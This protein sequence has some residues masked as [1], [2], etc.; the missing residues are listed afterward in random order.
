MDMTIITPEGIIFAGQVESVKLPGVSGAFIVLPR[1][2]PIISALTSGKLV[3][4]H[5]GKSVEQ[6]IRGGFVEVK[7]NVV[8]VCVE[9]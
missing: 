1:H 6:M 8:S 2:A 4:V 7:N 5:E 3:Y 9:V